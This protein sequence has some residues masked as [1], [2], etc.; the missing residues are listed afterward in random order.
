MYVVN[1]ETAASWVWA[2]AEHLSKADDSLESIDSAIRES[3][4]QLNGDTLDKVV[5]IHAHI[6]KLLSTQVYE[7]IFKLPC[8]ALR[9][10]NA[11]IIWQRDLQKEVSLRDQQIYE[12]I[13]A[14]DPELELGPGKVLSLGKDT[15]P[16]R[17]IRM[18]VAWHTA[19]HFFTSHNV[20]LTGRPLQFALIRIPHPDGD[21]ESVEDVI[22]DE[23]LASVMQRFFPP[24][25]HV[26]DIATETILKNLRYAIPQIKS[27]RGSVHCEAIL[28][29]IKAMS[30]SGIASSGIDM[31]AKMAIFQDI[32]NVIGVAKKCCWCCNWLGENLPVPMQECFIL[33]G[34]HGM[35][36]PWSPPRFGIPLATL[37]SLERELMHK[38]Q[39]VFMKLGVIVI[40][41][42]LLQ[43]R[44]SSREP[45]VGH[46]P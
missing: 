23:F 24:G 26:S 13:Q 25:V 5:D 32:D 17:Y 6:D 30:N 46:C 7:S 3:H 41:D 42:I 11:Q 1:T 38:L 9:L 21:M 40:E 2:L 15:F 10:Y 34:S 31:S 20:L 12:E 36:F 45:E 19:V 27:F 37:A 29:A 22:N 16:L 4:Q 8:L 33:P 18:L 28:M 14:L 35:I 43:V 44:Q 39:L